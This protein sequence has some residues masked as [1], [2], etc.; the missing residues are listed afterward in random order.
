MKEKIEALKA[1]IDSAIQETETGRA[2]YELKLKFQAELK[3]IMSG[4]RDLPKEERPVFGKVINEFK[5]GMEQK[6]DERA[7]VV[8]QKELQKKYEEEKID[9]TMPGRKYEAGALH[10]GHAR[11]KSAH[12]HFCGHG[13]QSL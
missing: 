9:V 2:L 11:E 12:R 13:L 5:E 3:S 7:V 6:F 4:M 1:K 8:R 10:P